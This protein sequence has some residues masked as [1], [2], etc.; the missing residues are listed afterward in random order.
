MRVPVRALD[1]AR[2]RERAPCRIAIAN[3]ARDKVAGHPQSE[4]A[5]AHTGNPI[6][7]GLE[8][9]GGGTL[10]GGGM[11]GPLASRIRM[12]ASPHHRE[13]QREIGLIHQPVALVERHRIVVPKLR[14]SFFCGRTRQVV[15]P[16]EARRRNYRREIDELGRCPF[17]QHIVW[18]P[19]L[20]RE[21]P[22]REIL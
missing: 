15:L 17:E 8:G 3:W 7:K 1:D 5:V 21:S 9:G 14:N 20:E 12:T 10:R 19:V 6:P 22:R 18:V 11:E 16:S 4:T 13:W 2:A